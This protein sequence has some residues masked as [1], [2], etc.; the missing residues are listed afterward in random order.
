MSELG[1]AIFILVVGIIM[2]SSVT[3]VAVCHYEYRCGQID[4]LSGHATI[5]LATQ[6]DGE[7]RWVDN[8]EGK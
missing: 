7:V 5:H 1:F 2:G 6:P 4:A 3:A 8:G